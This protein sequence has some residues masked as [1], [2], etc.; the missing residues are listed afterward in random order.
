MIMGDM[1]HRITLFGRQKHG[2]RLTIFKTFYLLHNLQ[3]NYSPLAICSTKP[4]IQP[5]AASYGEG[6][7]CTLDVE[8]VV[9]LQIAAL[10][11]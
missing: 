8:N 2:K 9:G 3:L 10:L 5:S 1:R 11:F 4:A 7:Q 6:A